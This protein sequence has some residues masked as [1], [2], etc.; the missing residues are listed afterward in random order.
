MRHYYY[1][2]QR[3]YINTYVFIILRDRVK[4]NIQNESTD[5]IVSDYFSW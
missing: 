4:K 2:Q 5:D 3:E 1:C